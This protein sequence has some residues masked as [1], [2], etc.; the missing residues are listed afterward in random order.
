M[1]QMSKI[2]E[3]T[4]SAFKG[5][6]LESDIPVVVDFWAPWC[7][8]CR[9]VTPVLEDVS[10][11]MNGKIKFVKLNTDENQKIAMDYQI[12]AIPSLLIFKDGQEVDRIVGLVPQEQLEADLQ[13]IIS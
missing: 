7:G 5:E 13:K 12:M 2:D 3:I 8:P 9:M 6:V 4:S 1:D 10:Q 11:K